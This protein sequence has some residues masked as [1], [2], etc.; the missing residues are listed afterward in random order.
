MKFWTGQQKTE[1][2]GEIARERK[3]QKPAVQQTTEEE[4]EEHYKLLQDSKPVLDS[5]SCNTVRQMGCWCLMADY[6]LV[7]WH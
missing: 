2:H 4:E 5:R 1:E 7:R 3:C 6:E